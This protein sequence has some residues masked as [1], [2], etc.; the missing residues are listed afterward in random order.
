[1]TAAEDALDQVGAL[2]K[3]AAILFQLQEG[4]APLAEVEFDFQQF[5]QQAVA[6]A[7]GRLEQNLFDQRRLARLAGLL[8]L[9]AHL[10]DA[11]GRRDRRLRRVVASLLAHGGG[12]LEGRGSLN[13]LSGWGR[14]VEQ[15]VSRIAKFPGVW[16]IFRRGRL[17]S[18]R[19]IVPRKHGPDPIALLWSR[20][21]QS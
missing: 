18:S 16:S 4:A 14:A 1:M 3:S 17:E 15:A 21:R 20:V 12:F 11:A 13:I 8:E 10:V 5:R 6:L 7:G 19:G 2:G 9:V